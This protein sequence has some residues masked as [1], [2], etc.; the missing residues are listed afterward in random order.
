MTRLCVYKTSPRHL[1]ATTVSTILD[2]NSIDDNFN[3]P[4][5][6][7]C[8][9]RAILPGF[10]FETFTIESNVPVRKLLNEPEKLWDDRVPEAQHEHFVL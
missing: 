9:L 8:V 2:L 4:K 10:T 1:E 3:S 7:S 5:R 6:I